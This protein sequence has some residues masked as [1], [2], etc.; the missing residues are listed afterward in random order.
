MTIF[1]YGV[2]SICSFFTTF[3]VAEYIYPVGAIAEEH[4]VF[5]IHQENTDKLSLYSYNTATEEKQKIL[6]SVYNPASFTLLPDKK[7]FSFIDHDTICI[8]YFARRSPKIVEL[9]EALYNFS[10]IHWIDNE[11]FYCSAQWGEYFGIFLANR[12][13][14]VV[15]LL[16]DSQVDYMYPQ[17][18]GDTLYCIARQTEIHDDQ[19]GRYIYQLVKKQLT[20]P[21][22]RN[23]IDLRNM[24]SSDGVVE[25]VCSLGDRPALFLYM[26]DEKR[27]FFLQVVPHI[28]DDFI[29]CIYKTVSL[30]ED[31]LID[32]LFTFVIPFSFFE[33]D[34]KWRMYESFLPFLP[35]HV[36]NSTHI[37]PLI[38]YSSWSAEK[39]GMK[40]YCYDQQ[41]RNICEDLFQNEHNVFCP[42]KYVPDGMCCGRNVNNDDGESLKFLYFKDF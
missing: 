27:C 12:D 15:P 7:G 1:L 6:F 5:F 10:Q 2:I 9:S 42:R 30:C 21:V 22:E 16:Y 26:M 39:N 37:N 28:Y 40:I 24:M 18:V 8:Q 14:N 29:H 3:L 13:G 4:L 23:K 20:L 17:K 33:S 34:S 31:N 41:K 19:Q 35:Y 36:Y 25:L 32:S 11:F 38:Y